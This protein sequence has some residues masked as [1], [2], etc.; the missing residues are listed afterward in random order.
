MT[1]EERLEKIERM[2]NRSR[3]INRLLVVL[4]IGMVLA[5]WACGQRTQNPPN[6]VHDEIRAR[7]FTMEDMDGKP[8]A[9]LRLF[10]GVPVF[11]LNDNKGFIRVML[12]VNDDGPRLTLYDEKGKNSA[13]LR[14]S[15]NQPLLA[16]SDKNGKPRA[17]LMVVDDGPRFELYDENGNGRLTLGASQTKTKNGKTITYPESSLLLYDEDGYVTWTAP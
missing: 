7:K 11:F 5:I 15:N 10:E 13:L 16:L 1:I 14:V 2:L 8:R 9:V 3:F 4:G 12:S 17:S 6:K